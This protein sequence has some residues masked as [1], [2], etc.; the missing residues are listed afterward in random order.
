MVD[1]N[2]EKKVFASGK[3]RMMFAVSR[4]QTVSYQA[5]KGV[6]VALRG[7]IDAQH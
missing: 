1:T 4:R 5:D 7:G 6:P 2:D 3:L